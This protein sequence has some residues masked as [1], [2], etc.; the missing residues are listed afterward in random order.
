MSAN[1]KDTLKIH[2]YDIDV[3]SEDNEYTIQ[4][5]MTSSVEGTMNHYSP[6]SQML[7]FWTI[8]GAIHMLNPD[9]FDEIIA[10]PM[11]LPEDNS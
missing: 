9:S 8:N 7:T 6:V 10:T 4:N 3:I 11:Y 1:N 2:H 5:V